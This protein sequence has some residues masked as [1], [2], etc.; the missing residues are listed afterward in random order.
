MGH[1]SCYTLAQTRWKYCSYMQTIF[2]V[3]SSLRKA[4]VSTNNF[5]DRRSQLDYDLSRNKSLRE[6]RITA[7]SLITALR[8]RAPTTT[9]RSLR[10]V[11]S[12]I[13]SP[14]FF[15]VVVTYREHD[16][17][18]YVYTRTKDPRDALGE[19]SAW[20]ERQFD[21]FREMYQAR[22]FQLVLSA[23]HVGHDSVRELEYAVAAETAK[24]GLP[25]KL[26]ITYTL[27]VC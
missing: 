18:H 2:M 20:Y 10:A 25:P 9:P 26:S 16:F 5:T 19:E 12:T 8:N 14:A 22:N 3:R 7:G 21:M 17:Y 4:Y 6:L 13:K 24:G 23:Y 11:L 1:S 15:K 27:G